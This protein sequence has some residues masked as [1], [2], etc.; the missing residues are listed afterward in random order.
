[1]V[2]VFVFVSIGVAVRITQLAADA[3]QPRMTK[4][5][6]DSSSL[7]DRQH[8]LSLQRNLQ[9]L[10]LQSLRRFVAS[11]ASAPDRA[12]ARYAWISL[13]PD[14][15]LND[16]STES[17][18][19]TVVAASNWHA[20][21]LLTDPAG[22]LYLADLRSKLPSDLVEATQTLT[23]DW[24][25][26]LALP[27]PA[28]TLVGARTVR[29]GA[30]DPKAPV[31]ITAGPDGAPGIAGQDDNLNGIVDDEAELGST[32]SDDQVTSPG[33]AGFAAAAA[34]ELPARVLSHGAVVPLDPSHDFDSH[35]GSDPT[36]T[37]HRLE[38]IPVEIW[39]D[40]LDDSPAVAHTL[41]LESQSLMP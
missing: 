35:A 21:V 34:G 8:R 33:Y 40:F 20:T 27:N 37:S 1:M 29:V 26:S 16:A 13:T 23:P 25:A 36:A 41:L 31:Y 30:W 19:V 18:R 2:L 10:Q 14:Q 22:Q 39:I 7:T 4:S 6:S 9:P 32:G 28:I 3:Y 5:D 15:P 24:L 12:T 17:S 11:G 38:S